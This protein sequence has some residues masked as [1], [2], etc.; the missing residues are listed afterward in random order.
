MVPL[1]GFPKERLTILLAPLRAN[2]RAG[3]VGTS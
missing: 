3:G 1:Y 2:F